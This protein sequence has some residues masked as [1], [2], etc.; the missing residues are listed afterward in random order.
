M[1]QRLLDTN[2]LTGGQWVTVIALSLITP[3]FVGIDKA[4]Q[5]SRHTSPEV[6]PRPTASVDTRP[7]GS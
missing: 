6:E 3:T 2:S 4:I 1:L 5:M 7:A